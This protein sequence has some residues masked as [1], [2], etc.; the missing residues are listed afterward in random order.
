MDEPALSS[1]GSAE[2][3]VRDSDLASALSSDPA[4]LFPAVFA[5]T[6]MIGLMEPACAKVPKLSCNRASFLS[7]Y[8]RMVRHTAADPERS[9]RYRHVSLRRTRR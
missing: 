5:T 3:I 6:R 4:E 2:L 8:Q 1:I 9:D 7:A